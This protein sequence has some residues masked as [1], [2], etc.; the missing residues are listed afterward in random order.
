MGLEK[1]VERLESNFDSL[2][3]AVRNLIKITGETHQIIQENQRENR[4]RFDQHDRDIA[5]LKGDVADLKRGLSALTAATFAGFKR[6]DEQ[7]ADVLAHI[8]RSDEQHAKTQAQ[9]RRS[10]EQH[11][12]TQEQIRQSNDQ[13]AKTQA[14]LKRSDEQHA[15]TQEQ[16][17]Q[18]ELLIRQL[19]PTN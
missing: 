12:K 2:D 8:K 9:L 14:Q 3:G 16:L 4:I 19:H 7:H 10:D 1:R 5:S 6:C 13:H 11:A 17:K 18:L 15:K